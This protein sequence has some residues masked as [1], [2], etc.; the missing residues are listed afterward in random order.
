MSS[1]VDEFF[2]QVCGDSVFA[3]FEVIR[4]YDNKTAKYPIKRPYVSFSS[5][6]SENI[7]NVIG[8]EGG[9]IFKEYM[10]V[11]ISCDESKGRDFCEKTAKDICLE[12]MRL[13]GGRHI[14]SVS[15]GQCGYV[16]DIF[17]Y[18]VVM[19]FGLREMYIDSEVSD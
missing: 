14:T 16:R 1:I 19:K 12:L 11:T 3:P 17:G 6:C 15:I 5:E 13:D 2:E 18:R 7:T 9:G 4:A 8:M 10:T